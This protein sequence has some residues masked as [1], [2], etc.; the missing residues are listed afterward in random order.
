MLPD[1]LT[2]LSRAERERLAGFLHSPAC[3][4]EALGL[5]Y[6][7][8]LLSAL[9]SGPEPLEP[10]EWLRLVLDEP[11]FDSLAQAEEILGLWLRWYHEIEHGLAGRC[12]FLPALEVRRAGERGETHDDA[13]A[14]CQGYLAAFELFRERWTEESLIVLRPALRAI[15]WLAV[16]PPEPGARYAERCRALGEAARA[17]YRYWNAKRERD[18]D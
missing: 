18:A 12:E 4:R 14:W 15:A 1:K 11:V 6:A 7:H 2:P 10:G 5:S 9:A 13:R 17:V 8:G 16:A 3:G